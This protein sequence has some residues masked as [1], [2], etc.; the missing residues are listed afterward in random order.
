MRPALSDDYSSLVQ[1]LRE[2]KSRSSV[3]VKFGPYWQ[4]CD[5]ESGIPWTQK[6]RELHG[7][8]DPGTVQRLVH[9]QEVLTVVQPVVFT[10]SNGNVS[11]DSVRLSERGTFVAS[12]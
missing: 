2:D 5:L 1:R 4:L 10:D 9:Q 6:F 11:I 12:P 7:R 8:I 3:M